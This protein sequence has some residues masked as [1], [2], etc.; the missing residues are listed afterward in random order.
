MAWVTFPL[1]V[2]ETGPVTLP[3]MDRKC[4]NVNPKPSQWSNKDLDRGFCKLICFEKTVVAEMDWS[5]FLYLR[6]GHYHQGI[7]SEDDQPAN[8]NCPQD[9]PLNEG[10]LH[11]LC[12]VLSHEN[13]HA[14]LLLQDVCVRLGARIWW[15][16]PPRCVRLDALR[17]PQDCALEFTSSPIYVES[18]LL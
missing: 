13:K 16:P 3:R 8:W 5:C 4:T 6:G 12:H 15:I 17:F 7:Y 11:Y 9:A 10:V 2:G 14:V 1:S 18:S